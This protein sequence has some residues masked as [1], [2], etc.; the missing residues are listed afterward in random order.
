MQIKVRDKA[1]VSIKAI[2]SR[3]G[4]STARE[5]GNRVFTQNAHSSTDLFR[6][7]LSTG[8]KEDLIIKDKEAPKDFAFEVF[9][10]V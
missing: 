6:Q 9:A 3:I 7:V 4:T 10:G 8:I 1:T 2:G 5:N